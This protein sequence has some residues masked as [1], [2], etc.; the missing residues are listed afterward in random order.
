MSYK[1]KIT[2]YKKQEK[3]EI[4]YPPSPTSYIYRLYEEEVQRMLVKKLLTILKDENAEIQF[5]EEESIK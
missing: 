5:V 3:V 2:E 1:V 4:Q